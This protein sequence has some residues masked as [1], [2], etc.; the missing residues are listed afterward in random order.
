LL[1]SEIDVLAVVTNP[2]RPAGRGMEMHA[3]PVKEAAVAA[4]LPILQPE[5]A[6]D[7]EFQARLKELDPDVAAVVAYGKILPVDLLSIPRLGFVNVHFSL[8]PKYR[9]A[10][11]VQRAII[12]GETE[13]GVSIMVLTEGMDEGP[14]LASVTTPIEATDTAGTV[15]ERLAVIGGPLLVDSLHGFASGSIEPVEQDDS[16]ATY[17]PKITSDD[18]R[19]DWTWPAERIGRFVRGLNPV[20]VAWSTLDGKRLKVTQVREVDTDRLEPGEILDGKD[21]VVG[22]GTSPLEL[23][24]VQPAGKKRM[25]GSDLLRGLRLEGDRRLE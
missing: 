24:E 16:A 19:I 25:S 4:G 2:D 14:V 18:A 3:S 11:P 8:L 13:T 21:L 1:D 12:E 7:P 6:R 22:T 9:G 23:V 5:K 17:A 15:G 20:P 10:A